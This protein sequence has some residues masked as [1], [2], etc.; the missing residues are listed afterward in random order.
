MLDTTSHITDILFTDF[1]LFKWINL[2]YSSDVP[3]SWKDVNDIRFSLVESSVSENREARRTDSV[4]GEKIKQHMDDIRVEIDEIDARGESDHRP[5][6]MISFHVSTSS[7]VVTKRIKS[8]H[9]WTCDRIMYRADGEGVERGIHL[10][11]Q[12]EI[13]NVARAIKDWDTRKELPLKT[14]SQT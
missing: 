5:K 6:W 13:E 3:E 4:R 11:S 7:P 1:R 8:D 9:H 2:E 10:P 12:T 14:A